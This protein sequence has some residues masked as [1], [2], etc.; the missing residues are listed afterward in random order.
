[1]KVCMYVCVCVC[2]CVSVCVC[3]C[4]LLRLLLLEFMC[5]VDWLHERHNL[6][7]TGLQGLEQGTTVVTRDC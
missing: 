7:A 4:D 1:M 5:E 3:V 6:P 2:V